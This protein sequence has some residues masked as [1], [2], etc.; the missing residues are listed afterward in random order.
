A[1]RD[2]QVAREAAAM[3]IQP[4]SGRWPVGSL[5]LPNRS[6]PMRQ[7]AVTALALAIAAGCAHRAADDRTA[8]QSASADAAQEHR[9]Q[10][11]SRTKRAE[12]ESAELESIEV[13]G[14]RL[15]NQQ[16]LASPAAPPVAYMP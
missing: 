7:I 15:M 3:R 14:S 2:G 12:V 4:R 1:L 13:S 5:A 9:E 6:H 16:A 8:Q 11:R 10:D